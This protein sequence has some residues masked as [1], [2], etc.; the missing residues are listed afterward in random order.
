MC[1]RDSDSIIETNQPV[2]EQAF[3]AEKVGT[4]S[5]QGAGESMAEHA[6]PKHEDGGSGLSAAVSSFFCFAVGALIPVLPYIFGLSGS[7]AAIVACVMVG[8]AL[9]F[10]GSVVGLLSGVEPGRRALRQLLIGF[11]AA[12]ATYL[13]GSLFNV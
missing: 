10:T 1:I 5:V 13:L 4:V 11:G 3:D 7:T 8:L 9:M 2:G 6:A 12:G